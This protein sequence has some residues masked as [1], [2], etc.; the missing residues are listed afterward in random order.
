MW[1][2]MCKLTLLTGQQHDR[3]LLRRKPS[4]NP[5]DPR[6]PN[7]S[8]IWPSLLVLKLNDRKLLY[9]SVSF[10]FFLLFIWDSNCCN[11]YCCCCCCCCYFSGKTSLLFQFAYNCASQ[12]NANVVFMCNHSRLQSKRPYLSQPI[13]PSSHVFKLIQM[14]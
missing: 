8:S 5:W 10:T 6:W 1:T 14:K 7:Y 12:S 11:Y 2:S 4:R 9:L 13:D 3:K